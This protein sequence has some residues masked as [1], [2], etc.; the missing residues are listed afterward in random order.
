[1]SPYL[2]KIIEATSFSKCVRCFISEAC[3][4]LSYLNIKISDLNYFDGLLNL[5]NFS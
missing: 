4:Y 5:N 2:A 3:S 1:M